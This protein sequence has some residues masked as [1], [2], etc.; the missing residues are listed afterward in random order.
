[1]NFFKILRREITWLLANEEQR[2]L[3][4]KQEELAREPCEIFTD[5]LY[6]ELRL[7]APQFDTTQFEFKGI[8]HY[9]SES[10][11]STMPDIDKEGKWN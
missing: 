6:N 3:I 7:E 10:A 2:T 8:G 1:M 11:I 4:I 5:T 9:I